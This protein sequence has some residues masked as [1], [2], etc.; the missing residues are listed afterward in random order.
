DSVTED[1]LVTLRLR[2]KGIRTVYL[3]E[4]LS[5]GLAP[6]GL[7]EYYGQRSRWCLGAIQICRGPSGPLNFRNGLP[8][9]VPSLFLLF[10]I[11]AVHASLTDAIAYVGP[12]LIA[13]VVVLLWLTEGRILPI[14]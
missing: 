10:G 8:F 6:E 5:L 11:Q 3:N 7:K 14:M 2:E 9:V 4:V 1:F 12:F 13:Q